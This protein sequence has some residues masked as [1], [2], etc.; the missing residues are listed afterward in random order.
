MARL[1]LNKSTLTR[2]KRELATYREF[3]PALELKRRQL[4]HE[5]QKSRAELA[6]LEEREARLRDGIAEDLPMLANRQVKVEGLV[7]VAEFRV[8][9][10]NI[11]GVRVPVCEDI[12]LETT[13]YGLMSKPHWV[14][15]VV[16]RWR[17]AL[18]DALEAEIARARLRAIETAL[19][20]VT[21]RVNLF[22]KVLIPRTESEIKRI[23]IALQDAERAGVIRAKV[24]KRKSRSIGAEGQAP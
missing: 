4:L 20:R 2:R 9:A 24:A 23:D 14:D 17:E 21:Q 1:P 5:R 16:E 8:G 15:R 11:A 22:D 7:R 18:R 6:A 10:R 12:R 19:A 3:L 13:P